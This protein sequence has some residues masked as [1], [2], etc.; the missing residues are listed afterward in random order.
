MFGTMFGDAGH[1]F[2]L[3]LLA[4]SFYMSN[5]NENINK[6]KS[7]ITYDNLDRPKVVS[8]NSGFDDIYFNDFELDE[9]LVQNTYSEQFSHTGNKSIEIESL[10]PPLSPITPEQSFIIDNVKV[11]ESY[12]QQGAIVR[13]WAKI[14]S[15][16]FCENGAFSLG[17]FF[18]TDVPTLFLNN[19]IPKTKTGEWYLFEVQF[20]SYLFSGRTY[21]DVISFQVSNILHT[22]LTVPEESTIY[23]DD[24]I[25]KPMNSTS[26]CYIYDLSNY[27]ITATLDNN[28]FASILQYNEK[29]QVVRNIIETYRGMKTVTESQFNTPRIGR[30]QLESNPQGVINNQA[31]NYKTNLRIGASDLIDFKK[32]K[33]KDQKINSKFNLLDF[34][35]SQDS[36]NIRF[37]KLENESAPDT[38][39]KGK[40]I[41][42]SKYEELNNIKSN[43]II[44]N[45]PND[46][47]EINFKQIQSL[48]SLKVKDILDEGNIKSRKN[49]KRGK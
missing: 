28:H 37:F 44:K 13:F 25:V 18:N 35:L 27:R 17:Y 20:P 30:P 49:I 46:S 31:N 3:I 33:P 10:Y 7:S 38:L 41:F 8:T 16:D 39:S 1:G 12:I 14:E 48:D 9:G 4:L 24:I 45:L 23:L 19:L 47:T 42:E 6:V 2:C 32:S 15:E 26:N 22:C 34:K 43:D 36:T 40:S 21:S 11:S 29:G 5:E